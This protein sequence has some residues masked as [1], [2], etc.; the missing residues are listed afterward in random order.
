MNPDLSD[1]QRRMLLRASHDPR[2]RA[3][4]GKGQAM[5]A[6]ILADAGLGRRERHSPSGSDFL[7]N[8]AGREAV[9]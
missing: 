8:D 7:I 5:T 6:I 2:G 9:A 4:V 3:P 1:A